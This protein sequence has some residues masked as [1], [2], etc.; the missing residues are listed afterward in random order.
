MTIELRDYQQEA[1]DRV[2]QQFSKGKKRVCFQLSTGGGKT[3]IAAFMIQN[4]IKKGLKV[5]FLV[6][7]KELIQ[8]TSEKI[9]LLASSTA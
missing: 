6:H 4:A 3:I 5:L 8:Q 7:L 2:R 9:A 1:I